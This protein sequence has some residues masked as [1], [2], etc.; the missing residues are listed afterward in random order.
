MAWIETTPESTAHG[1]LA[2]L[3]RLH[4]DPRTG[5]VDNILRVHGLHAE[6]LAGHVALYRAVMHGRSALA[7]A[8]R[9]LIAVVVSGRNG[10]HY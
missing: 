6:G 8:D 9:E 5:E 2:E 3:Y 1:E 4:A 7:P 10:C